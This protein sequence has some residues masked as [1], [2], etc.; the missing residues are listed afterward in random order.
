MNLILRSIRFSGMC[1]TPDLGGLGAQSFLH[2]RRALS[3]PAA[4][5]ALPQAESCKELNP[6][7]PVA[8]RYRIFA[9]DHDLFS[10]ADVTFD[11]W[12]VVLITN[13]KSLLYSCAKH[14]PLERLFHSTHIRYVLCF[15]IDFQFDMHEDQVVVIVVV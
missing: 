7:S 4:P 1:L 13:P 6:C 5:S 10:F 14:E 9:F 8:S 12:P 3:T 11:K 15:R 2:P